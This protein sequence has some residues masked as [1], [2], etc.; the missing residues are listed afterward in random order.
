M[1]PVRWGVALAALVSALVAAAPAGPAQQIQVFI[2]AGQ[3]NMVGEAKPIS[4]GTGKTAGLLVWR[5]SAWKPAADPLSAIPGSGVSPGMTFGIK[6]LSHLPPGL[7]VGFIACGLPSTSIERWGA[8]LYRKCNTQAK[9]SGGHLAGILYLQGEREAAKKTG[10]G[11]RWAKGFEILRQEWTQA[12]G[13]VPFVLGQI[14][15]LNPS[16]FPSQQQVRNAQAAVVAA[17][18]DRM[19]LVISSDLANDGTHFNV[20]S[21]KTLGVRFGEAW[22][23]LAHAMGTA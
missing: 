19:A 11:S 3:S 20:A 7:T 14:G 18:P 23:A 1:R 21:E 5:N 12:V 13:V 15:T 16:K 10:G 22:F 8:D 17:H 6:V 4:A 9:A 2:L